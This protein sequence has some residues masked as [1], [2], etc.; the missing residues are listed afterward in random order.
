[1]CPPEGRVEWDPLQVSHSATS[2]S[3]CTSMHSFTTCHSQVPESPVLAEAALFL[4]FSASSFLGGPHVTLAVIWSLSVGCL[5]VFLWFS[6]VSRGRFLYS[7]L[8]HGVSFCSGSA[9]KDI[10]YCWCPADWVWVLGVV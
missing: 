10:S 5:I 7:T 4:S 8:F 6:G 2:L 1:M 3:T 9:G